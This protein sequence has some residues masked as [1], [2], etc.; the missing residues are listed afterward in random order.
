MTCLTDVSAMKLLCHTSRLVALSVLFLAM[1]LRAGEDDIP[2]PPDEGPA[3]PAAA[4]PAEP[5]EEEL[6]PPPADEE[7]PPAEPARERPRAA[8]VAKKEAPRKVVSQKKDDETIYV[9]QRKPVTSKYAFEFSP[10]LMQSVNDRFNVHTGAGFA[11]LFHFR[12]NF[13]LELAAGGLWG[14]DSALT[15]EIREK[16]FLKPEL[17]QLTEHT[18]FVTTDLQ[19]SPLYGKVSILDWVLGQFSTYF[20]IGFGLMGNRVRNQRRPNPLPYSVFTDPNFEKNQTDNRTRFEYFWDALG[21]AYDPVYDDPLSLAIPSQ[22]RFLGAPQ[23]TATIGGGLRFY[24]TDWFGFRFELRDYVQANRLNHRVLFNAE[25]TST[26]NVQN[27]YVVQMGVSFLTPR[28]PLG[29]GRQ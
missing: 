23:L 17:V 11:A 26:F 2:P 6:P 5:V 4:E 9:V 13:A 20:S 10:Q 3:P 15:R 7:A 28:L 27:T 25:S 21:E 24:L 16:E 29:G 1:P 12:E 18:W 8:P 19:W 14:R 22:M